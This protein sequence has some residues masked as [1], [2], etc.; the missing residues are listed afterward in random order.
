M[1]YLFGY[2]GVDRNLCVTDL[3]GS[4]SMLSISEWRGAN[5]QEA[6]T[7]TWYLRYKLS[8]RTSCIN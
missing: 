6:G 1:S 3:D 7:A 4:L 8:G 5:V 2:L